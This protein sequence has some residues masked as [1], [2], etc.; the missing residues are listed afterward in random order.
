MANEIEKRPID[1]LKLTLSHESV[2]E[3]FRNALDKNAPLFTTAIIDLFNGDAYLQKCDPGLVVIEALKSATLNLPLNKSLGY[4][5][6]VPYKG[7]PQ[8]QIGWKGYVQLAIRTGQYKTI[9]AG[10][11]Y[12]GQTVKQDFMKGEMTITGSP[13]STSVIGYFAY[14][15]LVSGFNKAI[16]WSKTQVHIHAETYS[17]S[18]KYPKSAW[19]SNPDEMGTKTVLT[20][21]LKN[22]GIMSIEMSTVMSTDDQNDHFEQ[23]IAENANQEIINVDT[24][25]DTG[26]CLDGD[27]GEANQLPND[28]TP[29][30]ENDCA[31][32]TNQPEEPQKENIQ[33]HDIDP[34]F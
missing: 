11:V 20:N 13:K 33:V 9:N 1:R 12:E 19:K 32:N 26:E 5:W 10:P 7:K 6:I 24:N 25:I 34:G 29:S 22:F 28:P 3:Q 15:E 30:P 21:L 31:L 4:A 16:Y 23:E 18:Y 27:P 17:S 14:F 2:Q 8:F